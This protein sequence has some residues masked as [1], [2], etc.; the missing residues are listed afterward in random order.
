[1]AGTDYQWDIF[2]IGGSD[3]WITNIPLEFQE[4][5]TSYNFTISIASSE[6]EK[7]PVKLVVNPKGLTIATF[8]QCLKLIGK[9]NISI[10]EPIFLKG[11]QAF[12][13]QMRATVIESMAAGDVN[14]L[15]I[16]TSKIT[17]FDN[18]VTM[19][20]KSPMLRVLNISN[21]VLSSDELKHIIFAVGE[22]KS[23]MHVNFSN[24][25]MTDLHV[26]LLSFTLMIN[27]KIEHVVLTNNPFGK[28]GV[29][30]FRAIIGKLDRRVTY[31]ID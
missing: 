24:T 6:P 10:S 25:G 30:A 16:E 3:E 4:K 21:A 14:V 13:D 12:I 28:E 18:F 22:N 17:H 8:T 2:N 11:E 7:H 31:K 9:H 1:M 20:K 19:I 23:L 5:V 29:D 15:W 27:T 26:Q